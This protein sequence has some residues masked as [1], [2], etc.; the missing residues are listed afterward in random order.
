MKSKTFYFIHNIPS[1]CEK[2]EIFITY[3]KKHHNNHKILFN[4]RK[5]SLSKEDNSYNV[6]LS[7]II[8]NIEEKATFHFNLIYDGNKY[9]T[10]E[11]NCPKTD[12]Y[13][14]YVLNF[15]PKKKFFGT[16][17]PL[18][19]INLSFSEKYFIFKEHIPEDQFL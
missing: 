19:T 15:Q 4:Y 17:P 3:P 7:S 12:S 11:N 5:N 1:K 13:F 14:F 6:F 18:N 10:E 9:K 16:T 2:F 8:L